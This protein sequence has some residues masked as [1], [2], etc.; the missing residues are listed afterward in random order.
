MSNSA[1]AHGDPTDH[2]SALAVLRHQLLDTQLGTTPIAT[3]D[4][5]AHMLLYLDAPQRVLELGLRHLV[6]L[7]DTCRGDA[8]LCSPQHVAY[9][10]DAVYVR[11]SRG[12]PLVPS[13]VGVPNQHPFMQA[14]WRAERPVAC[15]AIGSDGRVG[16]LRELLLAVETQAM[17]VGR[18]DHQQTMLGVFCLD[19]TD[20]HRWQQHEIAAVDDFRQRFLGPILFHSLRCVGSPARDLSPAERAAV[21]LAA[22]GLRYDEIA[23]R[24]HK[25]VHTIDHQ[26]RSARRKTG[27][28]NLADLVRRC[29]FHSALHLDEEKQPNITR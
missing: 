27:A 12:A 21:Q 8:G 16:T 20:A 22:R 11:P 1:S 18:I 19:F 9:H 14:V 7:S 13:H 3:L 26:L 15:E 24:L 4:A 10:P 2:V 25:S 28:R 17:L 29:G 6:L 23:R 5:V